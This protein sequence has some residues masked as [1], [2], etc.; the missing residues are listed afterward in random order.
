MVVVQSVLG[1]DSDIWALLHERSSPPMCCSSVCFGGLLMRDLF[2]SAKNWA[3]WMCSSL[4]CFGLLFMKVCMC[5]CFQVL[6]CT[7][8]PSWG[9]GSWI[10]SCTKLWSCQV[11]SLLAN[12]RTHL[13]V[14]WRALFTGR[15][16]LNHVFAMYRFKENRSQLHAN[17]VIDKLTNTCDKCILNPLIALFLW[18]FQYLSF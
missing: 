11:K 1:C 6:N 16:W 4:E 14:G 17:C 13:P 5:S 10:W 2:T 8:F 9:D 15:V 18:L 7:I 3:P 12:G